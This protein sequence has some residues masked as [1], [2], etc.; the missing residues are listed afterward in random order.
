MNCMKE[1]PEN[2]LKVFN[3][4]DI[5]CHRCFD[6]VNENKHT[7]IVTILCLGD[8][9]ETDE[10]YA[11]QDRGSYFANFFCLDCVKEI[12][13]EGGFESMEVWGDGKTTPRRTF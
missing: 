7:N 9:I 4:L 12:E 5:R 2:I 10:L 13:K 6:L 8:L 1:I 11:F 3:R